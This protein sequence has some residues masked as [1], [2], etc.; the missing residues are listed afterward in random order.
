MKKIITALAIMA[1]ASVG[2]SQYYTQ[3]YISINTNPGGL[4]TD[5]EQTAGVL[6]PQGWT[7][8]LATQTTATWSAS[9][10]IPFAFS[11]N[12]VAETNYKVSTTGVLTF[13]VASTLSAPSDANVAIPSALIPDKSVMAWGMNGFGGND[14]IISKTF[15]TAPYRQHWVMFSSYSAVGGTGWAYWS[16]MMEETT[17][18]LFVVDMRNYLT[19]LSLT[20]GVQVNG[21]TATSVAGSPNVAG[22]NTNGGSADGP[23][24]NTYYEFGFGTQPAA[25]AELLSVSLPAV[26]ANASSTTIS[27]DLINA[28]SSTLT[29]FDVKYTVNGGAV[30]SESFTGQSIM[31]GSK[32]TFTLTNPFIGTPG[33][34][35]FVFWVEA[36]GDA[37]SFN[38]TLLTTATVN[39][40]GSGTK[41]VLLEEFTTAP[42]QFCPDGEVIV[43]QIRSS[44]P[45][46]ISVGIH[47]GFGTDA[48]TIPAHSTYAAAFTTGAPTACIDRKIFPNET[49]VGH[50][51]GAW[52]ANTA[53]QVN[54]LTPLD[55][56][57]TG[58]LT[59]ANTVDITV[60][61]DF[62]DFLAN[63]ED[64]NVTV[65]VVEDSVVGTGSG[66]NQV[67]FY[68]NQAGHPYF[69][70][71][72]P[73]IGYPHRHVVRAL[74]T[75]SAWGDD[76]FFTSAPTLNSNYNKTYTIN[77][78]PAWDQSK[79]E[80]VAFVNYYDAATGENEREVVNVNKMKFSDLVVGV[81]KNNINVTEFTVYPNP[82]QNGQVNV[83]FELKKSE[84]VTVEI[85]SV[86]GEVVSSINRGTLAAGEQKMR[87]DVD[88]LNSGIYFVKV[89]AGNE[90]STQRVSVIK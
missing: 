43:D 46:A 51:R 1:T 21:T 37:R 65:F 73:I 58:A 90:V 28:G 7:T 81:A 38:D 72:N 69:G 9:Q 57:L 50:S 31:A 60:D 12:G 86:L 68:N 34:K 33:N 16:I 4:N 74:A 44:I 20:V 23:D 26:L 52:V 6:N 85:V 67:N 61:V 83:K 13:D 19:P 2:Y 84:N 11:F 55:I 35:D 41:K 63:W 42:C 15:G 5:V 25:D 27:G 88:N 77:L 45:E 59:A 75:T 30:V 70:T 14:A 64:A 22:V 76:T 17:N 78:N 48:M 32:G 56:T 10:T 47:A 29:A 66:Y 53:S 36:T 8:V 80:F 3:S 39:A 54:E 87:L 49:R 79:M 18:R 89:T 40:G 82:V 71:G 24:D 62:A